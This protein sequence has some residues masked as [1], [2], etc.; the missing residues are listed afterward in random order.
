MNGSTS[1]PCVGLIFSGFISLIYVFS[2]MAP[3][4]F[5]YPEFIGENIQE[6]CH[7]NDVQLLS[8]H[9]QDGKYL[10]LP[11]GGERFNPCDAG[12]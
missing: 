5:T 2:G 4:N 3:S 10:K 9:H 12:G 8:R 6:F 1:L 7:A 11:L